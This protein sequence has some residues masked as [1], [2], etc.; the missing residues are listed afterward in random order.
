MGACKKRCTNNY[1]TG[2]F[3]DLPEVLTRDIIDPVKRSVKELSSLI[4]EYEKEEMKE[5]VYGLIPEKWHSEIK[6]FTENEFESVVTIN[7]KTERKTSDEISQNFNEDKYNPK[8]GEI[9]EAAD[10]LAAFIEI[11]LEL[12][13]GTTSQALEEAKNLLR[14][15]YKGKTI[16]GIKFGDIYADFD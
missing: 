10:D 8:D 11:Y 12:R 16:S 3:H 14:E 5:K 6:M 7:G 1:F 15:E 9:V 4:K 13:S 2:L